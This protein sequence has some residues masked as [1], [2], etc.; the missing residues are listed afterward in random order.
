MRIGI[1]AS[2]LVKSQPTGV[3][4]ATREL[5]YAL[6]QLEGDLEYIL[7]TPSTLPWQFQNHSH[8]ISRIIPSTR[9][10]TQTALSEAIAHDHLDVWWSP[11]N[12]LPRKL[13]SK[14][15]AT[16]HDLA[17]MRFPRAYTFKN[18][19][20]SWL[21]VKRA[22]RFATK[23]IAVSQQ[24]KLDLEHYF[25]TPV[26]Q[27]EVVYNAVPST[28]DSLEPVHLPIPDEFILVVGGIEPRKNPFNIIH[29]FA[30]LVASYPNLH[31][32]FAGPTNLGEPVKDL[33]REYGLSD[34][35]HL[36]GFVSE[37]GLNTLYQ[38]AKLLLFPSLY[39]GF[40]LPILEAFAHDLPVVT[41]NSGALKEIAGE[42]GVLVEPTS[43][44]QIANG[45]RQILDNSSARAHYVAAGRRRLADFSWEKSARRLKD[46]I[47]SL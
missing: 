1:D 46:I 8:V 13:P 5:I 41:S 19:L 26:N 30:E 9:W 39:E 3:E 36:L 44:S 21:T 16:V 4:V 31:L 14:V 45:I 38:R 15:L 40:G 17:F 34:Q 22:R 6:L 29:A 11:S 43:P 42:A 35:V 24:T 23:I 32:V 10:W 2:A 18:W 37:M 25:N 47:T 28:I 12:I 20:S 27:I 33:T 7:Y